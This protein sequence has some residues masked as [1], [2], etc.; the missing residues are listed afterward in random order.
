MKDSKVL[1]IIS[2]II[3]PIFIAGI[4][5]TFLYELDKNDYGKVQIEASTYFET[6][7]FLNQYMSTLSEETENLI[8]RNKDYKTIQDNDYTLYYNYGSQNKYDYYGKI[9]DFYYAIVYKQ[10]VF[11]N[12]ELTTETNTLDGIKNYIKNNSDKSKIANIING[13]VE[14]DSQ[15]IAT[16]AIQYFDNFKNTYYTK[17]QK[18]DG[19]MIILNSTQEEI[20]TAIVE[21]EKEKVYITTQ[22]QDFE[23]YTSYKEELIETTRSDDVFYR[24]F[25]G[26]LKKYEKAMKYEFPICSIGAI[27]VMLY[28]VLSIGH[29]KGKKQIELNDFDKI[30]VEI[31]LAL[32]ATLIIAISIFAS[33]LTYVYSKMVDYSFMLNSVITIYLISYILLAVAITTIIK[34]IKAKAFFKYSIIGKIFSWCINLCKKIWNGVEKLYVATKESWSLSKRVVFYAWIYILV[35]IGIILVFKGIGIILDI[36][37]TIYVF[38]KIIQSLNQYKKIENHLKEMYEGNHPEKLDENDFSTEYKNIV[39][40]INDIS[41]GFD[42]A[43]EERIKSEHLKTE[44]ITNV[45]HDI[46]TPLTSIINYVDLLEKEKIDSPKA[47]EYIEVLDNK[48]QRLK[49]LT[50]DLI[51]ASKA[52]SGNLKLEMQKIRLT[53]L[54]KQSIGEFEDKFKERNLD[55]VTNYP[56]KD[57]YI[58][59]DNRYLYRVIENLFAN[60]SKYAL[61]NSRVYIEVKEENKRALV[62]IKNISKDSLNISVD[63]L[64]QRFVRGDKSRTTEGSGL[65]LSISESLTKLQKGK[66]TL[67]VDGDLFKVILDF[68]TV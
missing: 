61:E 41:K 10:K 40:Y 31:V 2:Y 33:E 47:K 15:I 30:P 62:T 20:N 64:M 23:I 37:L 19:N 32:S 67:Q 18:Q 66:F 51:E 9:K 48:S 26:S 43:I 68:E 16:K 39:M 29:K 42:K 49:K 35:M 45:S 46:K 38:Y 4:V 52:S 59:A 5:I 63:E 11:T 13:N 8:Y 58:L 24:E 53:E 50:E 28:L 44:L 60:V 17:D 3:L 34:R 36:S 22:I 1:K 21:N 7:S 25:I 12:V 57:L 55:I 14:A 27:L 56:E 6:D 54:I 65:G